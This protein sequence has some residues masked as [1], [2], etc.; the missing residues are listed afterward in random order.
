MTHTEKWRTF[1]SFQK[2]VIVPAKMCKFFNLAHPIC[3]FHF[4]PFPFV[5]VE[6]T[7]L[8]E[9]LLNEL[10]QT[11]EAFQK[12]KNEQAVVSQEAQLNSQSVVPLQKENER[13]VKENNS[14]HHEMIQ[15]REHAEGADLKWKG[16]CRQAQNEVQDLRFLLTQK[17]AAIA[18]LDQEGVKL[19]QKLDTVMEKIYAPSANQIVGGLNSEGKPHNVI[20]KDSPQFEISTPLAPNPFHRNNIRNEEGAQTA[21][22]T[23]SEEVDSLQVSH[24]D[25]PGQAASY[26][27]PQ[28]GYNGN[29][30]GVSSTAA[31]RDNEWASELRRADE[32]ATEVR[33]KYDELVK[34]TVELEERCAGME[35]QIEARDNEIVRLGGL[36]QGGQNLEKLSL[37]YQQETAEKTVSKLQN[38]IDFLNRENH[39]LQTQVD[40]FLKDKT[41]VDHLD[42]QRKEI[43]ELTFENSTLRKDLR[44]LTTVL[45]DFQE[46][47]FKHKQ[48]ESKREETEKRVQEEIDRRLAE[49]EDEKQKTA[50]E[51]AKAESLRAAFHADK[52]ALASRVQELESSLEEKQRKLREVSRRVGLMEANEDQQK[53]ELNFWNGKVTNMKRDMDFQQTFNQKMASENEALL[54]DVDSLKKHLE[55]KDKEQDLLHRQIKG[56]QE[57]ND[58]IARMYQLVQK[59]ANIKGHDL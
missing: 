14:L 56:L 59:V 25:H 44:E 58:R 51:R 4:C 40:L 52:T 38:Q 57:D 28:F 20:K 49:C 26:K 5:D 47:Q 11:T 34:N 32:R 6:S 24:G 19:R 18:R 27:A 7:A 21:T 10:M 12:L 16:A 8:V 17:D 36:Y 46:M 37:Q 39:R 15:H 54:S 35:T 41:I 13:L 31:I 42:Q 50:E 2:N 45:K 9:R 55:M 1:C 48:E 43:D 33:Q 23:N 53:N 30:K 3:L 29:Q 22:L